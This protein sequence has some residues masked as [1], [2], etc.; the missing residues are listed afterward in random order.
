MPHTLPSRVI[1]YIPT[2]TGLNSFIVMDV[3]H[4]TTP[5]C[6]S[7]TNAP[8]NT[9][10]D[11]AGSADAHPVSLGMFVIKNHDGILLNK[12]LKSYPALVIY[13]PTGETIPVISMAQHTTVFGSHK[14]KTNVTNIIY[15]SA[16]PDVS[17]NLMPAPDVSGNLM[18]APKLKKIKK[19]T[20]SLGVGDLS[21][22]VAKQLFELAVLKKEQCPITVEE[23]SSGNTA[24]MPCGHL[25]MQMAIEESFKKEANK[26]PW[27]RQL[28]RPTY[29]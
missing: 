7:L 29:V 15:T 12:H 27:C 14:L 24:V 2:R 1:L 23:F 26:C 21:P 11:I 20:S 3:T 18:P 19:T 16:Q 4:E 5:P 17:G 8:T 22:H 10:L 25:F 9:S 13:L 28:G 6:W